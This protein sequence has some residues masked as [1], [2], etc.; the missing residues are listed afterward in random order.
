VKRRSGACER[1]RE[2]ILAVLHEEFPTSGTALE[3]SAGTG[4]H[5]AWFAPRLPQLSWLPT[6]ISDEALESIEAWRQEVLA[7]APLLQAPRRLDTRDPDWGLEEANAVLCCNMI[8]ISPW[9]SAVGLFAGVGRI[10]SQGGVF[11]LYGPFRFADAVF[12]ES[13][14]AFDR[15]LRRRDPTWGIRDAEDLEALAEL[16]GLVLGRAAPMPAN[17]HLLVFRRR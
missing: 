10:L 8:H 2:P 3:I 6:D 16:N 4:M 5:T 11:C 14:E 17:N 15:S 7:G 1:N 12:A 13:N 9:A